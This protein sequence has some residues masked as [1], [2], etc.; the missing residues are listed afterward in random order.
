MSGD[1][2]RKDKHQARTLAVALGALLL[3][4][5][6]AAFLMLPQLAELVINHLSPGVGVKD[7]AVISFFVTVVILVVFAIAAGDGLLGELQ[8]VLASFF[9]FFVIVWFLV[10][11]IF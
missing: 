1:T 5:G 2:D 6:V 9:M 7:A 11:W 8:F 3:A 4:L 10:A